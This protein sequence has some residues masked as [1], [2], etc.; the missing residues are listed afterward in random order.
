FR[1]V[2]A[3]LTVPAGTGIVAL[4]WRAFKSRSGPPKSVQPSDGAAKKRRAY[5]VVAAAVMLLYWPATLEDSG[6]LGYLGR[7]A[8]AALTITPFLAGR[9]SYSDRRLAAIWIGTIVVNAVVGIS[10]G[11]RSGLMAAVLFGAGHV[12]A[13]PQSR[14]LIAGV[15][16]GLVM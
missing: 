7:I 8:A 5:L 4:T 13:L 6:T 10:A 15:C 11:T 3:I 1:A 14:R 12:S 2:L 9:D 16:A